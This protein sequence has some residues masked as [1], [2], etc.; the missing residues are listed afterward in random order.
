[1]VTQADHRPA[2]WALLSYRMPREPSTPRIAV[3]RKLK[4]LGAEHIGDGL[5]ALPDDPRNREHLEWIAADVMAADGEAAVW[6]ATTDTAT[7]TA[8]A[9]RMQAARELEYQQLLEEIATVAEPDADIETR[10]LRRLRRAFRAIERRDHFRAPS[11]D[12]VRLALDE[13]GTETG[14]LAAS[15]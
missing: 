2:R 1:M 15:T 13:L 12:R 8:L 10:T 11:R 4:R 7:S 9:E 14:R 3:W 6:A 5:V